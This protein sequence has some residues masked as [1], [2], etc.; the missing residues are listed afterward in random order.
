MSASQSCHFNALILDMDGVIWK[1][2]EPIG[3][4]EKI[5]RKL[6]VSGIKFAFVTNN[7]TRTVGHYID[8]LHGYGIPVEHHLVINSG[9][10][11]AIHLSTRYPHGGKVFVIGEDGL[12]STLLEFGF[13]YDEREPI[14]V[15]VGLDRKLTYEKLRKAAMFIEA[16]VEFIGT[17]PDPTLPT[18]DGFIPGTG[19]ILAALETATDRKPFIIGKP[20]PL[21]FKIALQRLDEPAEKTLVVGDR[22][23]TDI[24]GGIAANCPTGLVLSGVTKKD[25]LTNTPYQPTIVAE[26]LK[27]LVDL[28]T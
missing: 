1:D 10:G 24:A 12:I 14:A 25:D 26:D 21:L 15:V 8:R 6:I 16:G 27:S 13:I 23:M 11:T 4:L 18:P 28:I 9:L 7:A 2:S 5:F 20:Y 17:N 3:D 22:L 19:A